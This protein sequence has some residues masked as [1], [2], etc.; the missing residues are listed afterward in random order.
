VI[1][2]VTRLS[3]VRNSPTDDAKSTYDGGI[4]GDNDA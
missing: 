2:R 3:F 1:H 4:V